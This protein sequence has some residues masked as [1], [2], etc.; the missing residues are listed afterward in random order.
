MKISCAQVADVRMRF[1]PGG[2]RVRTGCPLSSGIILTHCPVVSHFA[3]ISINIQTVLL[4][5]PPPSHFLLLHPSSLQDPSRIHF[6]LSAPSPKTNPCATI[7]LDSIRIESVFGILQIP[8]N[9]IGFQD[10]SGFFRIFFRF[11]LRF[12]K[13]FFDI[14]QDCSKNF[15]EYF[16]EFS[17]DF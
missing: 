13:I 12:S 4:R 2:G 5:S 7:E 6:T 9:S 8:P 15:S 17:Q 16:P 10:F 14:F 1:A 3:L 11:P